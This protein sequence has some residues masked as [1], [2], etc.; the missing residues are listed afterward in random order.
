MR[1]KFV[2]CRYRYQAQNECPWASKIRQV[3]G[4][5]MCFESM[6]DYYTWNNQK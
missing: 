3:Y 4:G 1:T 6:N 5:Y 2:E